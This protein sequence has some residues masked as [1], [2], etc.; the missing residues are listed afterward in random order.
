MMPVWCVWF[1]VVGACVG[2]F[3]NVCAWRIPRGESLISPPS[4]CP[5]CG[6]LIRFYENIPIL[7]W[8]FLGGKCSSCRQ[9]I[10]SRYWIVELVTA[11]LFET[12]WLKVAL[13]GIPVT[14]MIPYLTI[15][16]LAISTSIIDFEHRIIPNK[17]TYPVI[18]IGVAFSIISPSYWEMGR[19]GG[20]WGLLA[21]PYQWWGGG[22]AALL[23]MG[24][25]GGGLA[26]VAIIG[27]AVFRREALGWG[28][29]KYL[30]AVGACL[31]VP[32]AFFTMLFGS[33]IG[34]AAGTALIAAG[35]GKL[36]SAIAFGPCLATGTYLW[37]ICG[38][39]IL[40]W[41]IQLLR[42]L[43]NTA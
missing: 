22:L 20:T 11:V 12:L 19:T 9:P 1:F 33:L 7:G 15:T 43:S 16:T 30:A 17:T 10:S 41:Y 18:L 34:T 40:R 21:P 39:N 8:F 37:I 36:K 26:L 14:A 23:G 25:A 29:V 4:H 6:H 3:L 31:G 35:R 32:G 38:D 2:S 27:R 5:K 28:D 24:A 13:T 42:N